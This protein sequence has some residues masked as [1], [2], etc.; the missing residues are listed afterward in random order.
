MA[1]TKAELFLLDLEGSF[2]TGREWESENGGKVT[3]KA[4]ESE[5]WKRISPGR[6]EYGSSGKDERLPR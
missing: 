4:G 3:G 6:I 2:Q 1:F 5:G